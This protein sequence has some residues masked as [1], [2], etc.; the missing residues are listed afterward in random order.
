MQPSAYSATPARSARSRRGISRSAATEISTIGHNAENANGSVPPSGNTTASASTGANDPI[1]TAIPG[2][3]ARRRRHA[4]PARF[5][6]T[7]GSTGAVYSATAYAAPAS[8]ANSAS[9]GLDS[10]VTTASTTA[11][12]GRRRWSASAVPTAGISPNANVSRPVNRLVPVAT[13]NHSDP[14]QASSP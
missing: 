9:T 13:P 10:A 2:S 3:A 5:V 1:T 6:A 8:P 11:R 7:A 4:A 14:S 12:A